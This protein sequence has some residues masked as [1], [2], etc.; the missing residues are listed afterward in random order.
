VRPW[1]LGLAELNEPGAFPEVELMRD[2]LRQWRF[3]HHFRSD[4]DS[5]LR[6]S[7]PGYRSPMLDSAGGNLAATFQTIREIGDEEAL[8]SA[9]AAAFE[10]GYAMVDVHPNRHF[11]LSVTIP[12]LSRPLQPSEFSDGQLRYLALA[13]ALLSPR[14]PGFLV[15]NEPETSLSAATLAH[16]GKLIVAA[17]EHSQ[18]W[19]TTHSPS[20]AD[21]LEAV[22][23]AA[24]RLEKVAGETRI[25]GESAMARM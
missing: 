17:K 24:V 15:L 22:G 11:E 19:L 23:A 4:P 20:L 6:T 12:G 2:R 9:V 5:P 10:G 18:V 14:P 8:D 3:Y 7:Q 25:E 13:C 21:S 16:L 1:E